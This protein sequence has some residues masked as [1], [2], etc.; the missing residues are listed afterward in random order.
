MR[1][2]DGIDFSIA[3]RE[4]IV[5]LGESGCGKSSLT[6]ALLRMLPRNV[7]EYSGSVWF[8]GREVPDP[9][10]SGDRRSLYQEHVWNNTR[11]IYTK[12]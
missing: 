11:I 12:C 10:A 1:A 9:Y 3:A 6:K 4:A 8:E 2:V 5:I 7:A